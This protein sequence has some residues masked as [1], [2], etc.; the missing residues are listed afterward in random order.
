YLKQP[1]ETL[2]PATMAETYASEHQAATRRVVTCQRI[3]RDGDRNQAMRLAEEP[4]AIL[5]LI[6]C[7]EFRK[8]RDWVALCKH[9]G[10][11]AP[12]P[13]DREAVLTLQKAYAEG[14]KADQD[15]V[16]RYRGAVMSRDWPKAYDAL[17]SILKVQPN[18]EGYQKEAVRLQK[19]ILDDFRLA[20]EPRKIDVIGHFNPRGGIGTVVRASWQE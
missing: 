7:L 17:Q 18:D 10:W 16:K 6:N 19:K 5:E 8:A 15:F 13:M 2:Q 14:D 20:C 1:D 9:N 11:S 12:E 4:P 3:I